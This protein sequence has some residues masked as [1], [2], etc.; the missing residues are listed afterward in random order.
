MDGDFYPE[1]DRTAK[2]FPQG[3]PYYTG[4]GFRVKWDGGGVYASPTGAWARKHVVG[5][6]EDNDAEGGGFIGFMKTNLSS[7]ILRASDI[8]LIYAEAIM[9]N[10]ESTTNAEALKAYNAVRKRSIPS[11]LSVTSVTFDEIFKERILELAYEGDNWFDYVR[12]FYYNETK[13]IE[14]LVQQDRG[15]YGGNATTVITLTS[16]NYTPSTADFELP[17]PDVDV[18]K[19]PNLL[20]D[21]VPFDFSLLKF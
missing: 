15:F 14:K 19:N 12:L 9:G 18:V 11:H 4:G 20:K 6:K 16:K 2:S 1:L 17:F 13:A 7:H 21:P 5:N 10:A 3:D 8:Y